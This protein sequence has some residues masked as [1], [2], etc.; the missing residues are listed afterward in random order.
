MKI[1]SYDKTNPKMILNRELENPNIECTVKE[2]LS[3]VKKR[4]DAALREYT[5]KFDGADLFDILVSKEEIS[6]A[7]KEVDE[8]FW[9]VLQKAAANIKEFHE[10]QCDSGYVMTKA[11]GAVMGQMT[12][13]LDRVGI[14][15]PG[16]T[17]SYPSTVLMNAIPAKLAKVG[18]IIMATPPNEDG[19]I[20]NE[21]LAAAHLAGVDRIYK[22]GGAQAVAA[23]AYGTDSVPKVDKIVGPGNAY[24]A[25]AKKQVFGLVDI[26]MIAGPSEI[27]IVA[28]EHANPRFLAADLLSQAEH[29]VLASAI[30]VTTSIELA[31]KVSDEVELQLA[32][33]S[34]AEIAKQSIEH[35]GKIILVENLDEAIAISNAI[36]PE[37]LELCVHDPFEALAKVRHAGSVFLG[38]YTPESLGDYLSGGNH[39]LPTLGT[40]RFA[41][42]LG[43]QDFVKK[44]QYT[45]YT[46]KALLEVAEDIALFANK[47][48]LTAHARA[49]WIRKEE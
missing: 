3:D 23:L 17:A 35:Q 29:D 31:K 8:E 39:T 30:L 41:S 38:H 14:Y 36:A 40:A 28:D 7:V 6:H 10:K 20:A 9:K 34:R 13:P 48:G 12:L 33:L 1:V 49:A 46:K 42:P 16:G 25:E 2:I 4:G 44:M 15:V 32:T 5:L 18:E 45:Y 37:H 11:S 24:V 27:L 22:V 21:I 19:K 43:V 26:D 47:E